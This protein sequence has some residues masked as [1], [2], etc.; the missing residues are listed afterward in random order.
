MLA[1]YNEYFQAPFLVATEQYYRAES[2]AFV[3]DN[4][5]AD[6]LRKAEGRLDEEMRRVDLY[7]H[8]TTRKD[9]SCGSREKRSPS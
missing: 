4:S 5:V 6:Y 8:D 1:V 2:A 9:V 3:E 7:L